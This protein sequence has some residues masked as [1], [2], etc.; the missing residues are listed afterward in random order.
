[1]ELSEEVLLAPSLPSVLA[2][3]PSMDR[4]AGDLRVGRRSAG[5]SQ[6]REGEGGTP[7]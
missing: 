7:E 1:M 6:G 3:A 2:E 4:T 5:V